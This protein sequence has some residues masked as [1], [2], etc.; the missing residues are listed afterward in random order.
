MACREAGKFQFL[1]GQR[2]PPRHVPARVPGPVRHKL[3]T[4]SKLRSYRFARDADSGV[5]GTRATTEAARAEG[6]TQGKRRMR[7]ERRTEEGALRRPRQVLTAD[8]W[9][10]E[11]ATSRGTSLHDQFPEDRNVT[12]MLCPPLIAEPG[13]ETRQLRTTARAPLRPA[14]P[15]KACTTRHGHGP[16]AAPR[17]G[18]ARPRPL[19]RSVWEGSC[20]LV[21]R[22]TAMFYHK[23]TW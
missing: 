14:P 16:V 18:A 6:T 9:Q 19:S 11:T 20:A 4:G 21:E 17:A 15:G 10:R 12:S 7:R 1:C 3:H 8:R 23:T 13:T 2:E 5:P 22:L